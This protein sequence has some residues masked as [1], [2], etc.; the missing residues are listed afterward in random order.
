MKRKPTCCHT[1]IFV[2]V[3]ALS[4]FPDLKSQSTEWVNQNSLRFDRTLDQFYTVKRIPKMSSTLNQLY[5]I[6]KGGGNT[7]TYLDRVRLNAAG[8]K[9]PVTLI[10]ENSRISEIDME[11]LLK[12]GAKIKAKAERSMR[13]EIPFSQLEN[14][15]LN[16]KGIKY[17]S[18][19][20]RPFEC[21]ITSE[22][23]VAMGADS[24]QVSGNYVADVKVAI[25]DGVFM[26]LS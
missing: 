6:Y 4:I 7:A 9:I 25:I 10:P 8:N 12:Y 11:A 5:D 17:I 21:V 14:I 22:G 1:G 2:F 13:A 16:V 3:L 15:A 19:P 23:V 26:K 24:W 20:I 18:E